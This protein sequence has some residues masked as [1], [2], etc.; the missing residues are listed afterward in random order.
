VP[1]LAGLGA[2]HWDPTARGTLL[3]IT[4]GTT[5]AHVARAVLESIAWSTYDVVEAMERESGTKVEE[6][7]ADGGATANSW[8]MQFQADILGIPVDVPK[9]AETTSL[10]SAYLAGLATGVFSDRDELA[11]RRETATRY[12]PRMSD[13][14]A[15]GSSRAGGGAGALPR[16]GPRHRR[17]GRRRRGHRGGVVVSQQT[18]FTPTD[19]PSSDGHGERYYVAGNR[20]VVRGR[21]PHKMSRIERFRGPHRRRGD[22]RVLRHLPA[23]PAGLRRGRPSRSWDWPRAGGAPVT[24]APRTG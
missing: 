1:A 22:G 7:R 8:L 21:R 20:T 19:V 24:S 23:H 18:R 11:R 9:N 13:A 17:A 6:L 5:R 16:L 3:G 10:G 15:T 14:T 2:P 12:E 4:R